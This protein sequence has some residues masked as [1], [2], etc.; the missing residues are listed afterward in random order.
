[1]ANHETPSQELNPMRR[2][3]RLALFIGALAL[4]IDFLNK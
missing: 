2:L 3:L 4:G 1:M